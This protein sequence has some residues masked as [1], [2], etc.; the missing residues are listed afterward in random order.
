LRQNIGK[1]G[2]HPR[3]KRVSKIV[4]IKKENEP[5][6]ESDGKNRTGS[7]LKGGKGEGRTS[8]ALSLCNEGE[9]EGATSRV[10]LLKQKKEK[11]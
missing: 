6:N 11:A 4:G 7:S 5:G 1:K 10:G 9:G 3:G 2:T 8:P